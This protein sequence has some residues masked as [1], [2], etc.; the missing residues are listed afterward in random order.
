M[1]K[2]TYKKSAPPQDPSSHSQTL[3]P[4]WT[5][6]RA[7]TGHAYYYNAETKQ[8]TYTRPSLPTNGRASPNENYS[9]PTVSWSPPPSRQPTLLVGGNG[10]RGG[11]SYQD[12][13]R[14]EDK[15]DRPKSKHVI[16]GCEPW[17]LV[18]TRLGRR[19]VY[20]EEKNESF[21]KFPPDIILAVAEMDRLERNHDTKH[22]K[23]NGHGST[24]QTQAPSPRNI[25]PIEERT[26]TTTS[27]G[28]QEDDSDSYEE[29][30]VTDDE[31]DE[32]GA[33]AKRQKTVESR[34]QKPLE[35]D[36][37]D[38]AFQLAAMGEDYGLDPEEYDASSM[39]QDDVDTE[40]N[41][42]LS[43][44]EKDANALFHDLLDD[45]HVNPYRPWESVIEDGRIVEDSRYTVLPNMRARTEAF[46]EWS[47]V[48]IHE[49]K[50]QKVK[51]ERKD[52]RI[53]YIRFLDQHATPKLYWPEF[54]RKYKKE[55]EMKDTK[56]PDK[57]RE[58]IYRDHIARL[59]LS[60]ATRKSDLSKL[61]RD[62]PPNMLN[63]TSTIET[64]PPAVLVDLRFISLPPNIRHT[65]IETYISTL[66][67]A[68]ET[69]V[70]LTLEEIAER[71]ERAKERK[72]REEA[73]AE[74]EKQVAE[75]KQKQRSAL[76]QGKD[77]MRDNELE[78]NQAMR[79]RK[80]G[81]LNYFDESSATGSGDQ[82]S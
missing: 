68:P 55:S 26:R 60:E 69:T 12:R 1:L 39:S 36:E 3:P 27:E 22:T 52:P 61:L 34:E 53:S 76:R 57:D 79:V 24:D 10:F 37:D 44:S 43:L 33:L 65:F 50:D 20:N 40:G 49:L 74:R 56:M 13:S 81:V 64:L 72:K 21:W 4:G 41:P 23:T 75:N 80:E 82:L 51:E 71:G 54:K 45:Y 58:R 78:L 25:N 7:P 5:E 16:P 77:L 38:I 70:D 67:D 6:H 14:R 19:F 30:E 9:N 28:G 47:R 11:R 66:P 59:K 42:G 35:F 29:V 15:P 62:M 48:R 73:L 32:A 18:K 17:I 46:S 2:T 31:G 63:R 8:S